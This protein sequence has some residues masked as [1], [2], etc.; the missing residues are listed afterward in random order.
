MNVVDSIFLTHS[1]TFCYIVSSIHEGQ[2]HVKFIQTM[3]AFPFIIFSLTIAYRIV[4]GI[5]NN[6][7]VHFLKR[8]F[9]WRFFKASGHDGLITTDNVDQQQDVNCQPTATYGTI[10]DLP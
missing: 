4:R 2:I 10:S 5:C 7:E 9:R 1:A 3:V 8:L 6:H